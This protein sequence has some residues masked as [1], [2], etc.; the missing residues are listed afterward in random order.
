[1]LGL[2]ARCTVHTHNHTQKWDL[3][4]CPFPFR[5]I[6][7]LFRLGY[8]YIMF[9]YDNKFSCQTPHFIHTYESGTH[10]CSRVLSVCVTCEIPKAS[11][12]YR[13]KRYFL[14]HRPIFILTLSLA[15]LFSFSLCFAALTSERVFSLDK[16]YIQHT[17][18]TYSDITYQYNMFPNFISNYVFCE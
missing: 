7:H 10:M 14:H 6:Q 5:S 4:G 11:R 15:N 17:R 12:F 13:E 1:M 3:Y 16:I 2:G 8:N 9:R 18:N